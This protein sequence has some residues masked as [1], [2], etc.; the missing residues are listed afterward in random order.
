MEEHDRVYCGF[1][2]FDPEDEGLFE[3]LGSGEF[4]ISGFPEQDLRGPRGRQKH[5]S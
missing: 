2:F 4:N 1:N 3:A 5:G